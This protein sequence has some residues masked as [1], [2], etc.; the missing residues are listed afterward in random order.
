MQE[1]YQTKLEEI[2]KI[3]IQNEKIAIGHMLQDERAAV[4]AS[5]MLDE[6]YFINPYGAY[7]LTIVKS[8]VGRGQSVS[9]IYFKVHSIAEE[10]WQG[11]RPDLKL[12][13]RDFIKDCLISAIN[14][15]GIISAAEGIFK[16]LQEQY[17]RR[18]MF[19]EFKK[20]MSDVLN[21]ADIKDLQSV[22]HHTINKSNDIID[23]MI[24]NKE[25]SYKE[26]ILKVLN[27]KEEESINTGFK[28]LDEAIG[29][30]KAGQ[31]ITIGAA[32]GVGK[33]AFAINLALNITSQGHKVGLWS[34]EM[35]KKEVFERIFS[36][37]TGLAKKDKLSTEERYNAVRKYSDETSDDIGI[38]TE[39]IKDLDRFYLQCRQM[40]MRKNM[41]VVIIDYLQL[42]RLSNEANNNRVHQIEGITTKLKEIASDLGIVIVILSQLSRSY[43][44]RVDKT[45]ILSDLRDSGSI[46]QDS[47]IVILLH[48]PDRQPSH[49][50]G[51]EQCT[52]V[53]VAKNRSGSS[54]MFSLKYISNLTK[55]TQG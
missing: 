24:S 19:V 38:Y 1:E 52:Q 27:H 39:Y 9:D 5:R 36:I 54:G 20:A 11:L 44:S 47:N 32:T 31:L 53:I 7:I 42:I 22:V 30:F 4:I 43:Q 26:E 14:F 6:K 50:N 25:E 37:K 40:S 21:T 3:A 41:K 48:R 45:P 15:V 10:D 28:Q 34:F 51:F 49:Y 35:D 46:E 55:F 12:G 29:G 23:C 33:S 17:L 2:Q 8:C 16:K 13:S 18:K